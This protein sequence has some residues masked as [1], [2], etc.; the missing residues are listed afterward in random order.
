M[1]VYTGKAADK[2]EKQAEAAFYELK[3][4]EPGSE[5]RKAK[6]RYLV[7]RYGPDTLW[8][9]VDYGYLKE[10]GAK[11]LLVIVLDELKNVPEPMRPESLSEDWKY[12]AAG[13]QGAG[14]YRQ[15][16]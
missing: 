12:N 15:S 16:K 2:L 3:A 11:A 10:Q 9:T 5:K 7:M 8:L 13:A 4:T 14:W 1:T 6:T